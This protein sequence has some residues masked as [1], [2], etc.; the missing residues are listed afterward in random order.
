MVDIVCP[1]KDL[2]Q[3]I[4]NLLSLLMQRSLAIGG[5]RDAG[6]RQNNLESG[7]SLKHLKNNVTALPT[8]G[9]RAA[10][11][12]KNL[13]PANGDLDGDHRT[14]RVVKMVSLME[15]DPEWKTVRNIETDTGRDTKKSKSLQISNP[16]TALPKP[17]PKKRYAA[18][19]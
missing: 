17:S 10:K 7:N 12:L 5:D 9:K 3:T 16:P 11:S 2:P 18:K 15:Q 14:A 4:G 6:R 19:G 8:A 1:R 13:V